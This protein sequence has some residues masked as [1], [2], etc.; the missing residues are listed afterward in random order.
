MIKVQI[1]DRCE[2]CNGEAYL[3][4][5]EAKSYSGEQ[6]TRYEPCTQCQGSGKQTR[7]VGLQEFAD[8]ID[9]AIAFEPDYMELAQQKP[10]TQYR[11]SC[12]AAGI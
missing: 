3:P 10:V 5:G 6:Y 1:L 9:R 8:L 11:D 12:E 7:W 4:V 2:H